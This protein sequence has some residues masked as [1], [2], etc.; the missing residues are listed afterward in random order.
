[1]VVVGVQKKSEDSVNILALS[2]TSLESKFRE[3]V[4]GSVG[5]HPTS[6]SENCRGKG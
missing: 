3:I 4:Y 1:M 2:F 6:I 5:N